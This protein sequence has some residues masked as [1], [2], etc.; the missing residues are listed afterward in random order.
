MRG[1]RH[2]IFIS[3]LAAAAGASALTALLFGPTPTQAAPTATYRYV[4]PG[5]NDAG[6]CT[7]DAPCRTVQYALAQ[8]NPGD[9]LIIAGGTYTGTVEVTKTIAFEGSYIHLCLPNCVWFRLSCDPSSTVLDGLGAGR[10]VS[11]HSGVAITINC[12]TIANG[13]AAGLGGGDSD[14]DAGGGV[15]A[16][17][18]RVVVLSNVVISNN[19]ATNFGYGGGIYVV[20]GPLVMSHTEVVSNQAYYGGGGLYLDLSASGRAVIE[21]STFAHNTVSG[22][23]SIGGGACIKG[24]S[25]AEVDVGEI[26]ASSFLTNS[27][28]HGGGLYLAPGAG[29]TFTVTDTLFQG[30]HANW[31]GGGLWVVRGHPRIISNTITSNTADRDGGGMKVDNSTGAII[32]SNVIEE[33]QARRGG[34][35]YLPQNTDAVIEGNWIA[36]NDATVAC[37]GGVSLFHS[38]SYLRNNFLASNSAL[39]SGAAVCADG[40]ETQM[41]HNTLVWNGSG[42]WT[43]GDGVYLFDGATVALTNTIIV[44]HHSA[45]YASIGTTATLQ[46]TLWGTDTWANDSDWGGAGTILTG[47][48]NLWADPG[49][50]DPAQ[51]DFHLDQGS[52]AI[53]RGVDAGVTADFDGDHRV[54]AP[55]LGADEYVTYTYLP[56]T[57]RNY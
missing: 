2:L 31:S 40:G 55:D 4:F 48:I 36:H 23:G 29:G 32:S 27:A 49:F 43:S 38:S 39:S 41:A 17:Y 1:R 14:K 16:Y 37:G 47:T 30:N 20:G 25:F 57:V 52:A 22:G 21:G 46:A 51:G 8:A 44:G 3:I 50:L 15:Y 45:I 34:G 56:L 10:A 18:P 26:V 53:G 9:T 11:I 7:Y 42:G 12:L 5:G 19:I 24:G 6:E 35:I 13:N 54:G 33:N 28:D